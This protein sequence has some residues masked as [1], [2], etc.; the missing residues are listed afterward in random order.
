MTPHLTEREL[1]EYQFKLASGAQTEEIAAHLADCPD[2]RAAL[3][4][5]K[6]TFAA[7]DLL[8]EEVAVSED[9]ISRVLEQTG[10]PKQTRAV[11]LWRPAWIG[12]A[13]AVLLIASLLLISQ[14]PREKAEKPDFAGDTR[15]PTDLP[16]SRE[17]PG[18]QRI[19]RNHRIHSSRSP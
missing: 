6:T 4:Q 19:F 15:K 17:I 5:L 16:I 3:E 8:R 12:A 18:N 1:I 13:A 7:L 2:C 9:L 14:S 11:P 10:K